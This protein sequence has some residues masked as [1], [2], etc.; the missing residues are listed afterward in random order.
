MEPMIK[1][2]CII[3]LGDISDVTKLLDVISETEVDYLSGSALIIATFTSAFMLTEIED[4]L[5]EENKSYIIFEMTPG[6]YSAHIKDENLQ[7]KLFGGPIDNSKLFGELSDTASS[8]IGMM[9]KKVYDA[10]F[11]VRTE[12]PDPDLNDILDR[13]SDV[14]FKNIT[15]KEKKLLKKYSENK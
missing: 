7:N 2:Y 9:N 15:D 3:G 10:E 13:I 8:I 1:S 6:F 11:I 12:E 5:K 14:G 4:L